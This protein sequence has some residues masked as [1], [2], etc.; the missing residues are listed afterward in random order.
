LALGKK[1]SST[2]INMI[3]I[4]R[5]RKIW[6]GLSTLLIVVSLVALIALGLKLGIDFTGGSLLEIEFSVDRP[7][8][9]QITQ[10]LNSIGIPDAVAQPVGDNGEI[11]R[12]KDVDEKTHQQIITTLNETFKPAGEVSTT[13]SILT[14][15]RF[16][17]IGPNIGQ[18][19][20]KKTAW[21]L[22]IVVVAITLY[23]AWAF[24]KVS[25]PIASWKYG[26]IAV[27]ALIHDILI[28][29]GFFAILGHFYGVEINAPFVAALLTIFGYSNNDTIVVFDRIR[30]NLVRRAGQDFEEVVDQ[31]INEVIVRSINT[32]L[33][34][35]MALFVLLVF[36]GASIRDFVLA[37]IFGVTIGTYSS[38]FLASPLLVAWEKFRLK[39]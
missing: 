5:G 2:Q 13:P 29:V 7:A 1:A 37:L 23:I 32:S 27:I 6:F 36:G 31:S 9:Q 38:V 12:F 35:L 25:K 34:V 3:S 17:S 4:I 16:D 30:E 10:A 11:I 22:I 39:K 14:E 21:A 20:K 33:T 26:I 8:T 18:E 19:L 15:K 24:R 28:T